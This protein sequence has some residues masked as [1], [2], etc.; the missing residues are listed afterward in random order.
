MSSAIRRLNTAC[1]PIRRR[2][3]ALERARLHCAEDND[4]KLFLLS[5]AAFFTCFYTLIF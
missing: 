3:R 4:W 2:A 5:F 1:H